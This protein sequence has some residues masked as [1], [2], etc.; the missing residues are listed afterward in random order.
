[1]AKPKGAGVYA[2]TCFP[3]SALEETSTGTFFVTDSWV[4]SSSFCQ[5]W[6]YT[7][8]ILA[9]GEKGQGHEELKVSLGYTR[10]PCFKNKTKQNNSNKQSQETKK[11]KKSI[12]TGTDYFLKIKLDM[13]FR[14]FLICV[15]R[16]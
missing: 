13:V 5:V 11:K 3:D 2:D 4:T 9:D 1:M 12:K 7:P 6:W 15:K 10:R 14:L 8:V 16:I